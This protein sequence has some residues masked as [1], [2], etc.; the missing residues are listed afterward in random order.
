MFAAWEVM[1]PAGGVPA[2]PLGAHVEALDTD[3]VFQARKG[4]GTGRWGWGWN[5][6]WV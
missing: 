6:G 5:L 2:G 4:W 3:R 1:V